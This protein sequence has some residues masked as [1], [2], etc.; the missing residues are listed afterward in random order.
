VAHGDGKNGHDDDDGGGDG[1]LCD[2]LQI[3]PQGV[4]HSAAVL[5]T[6]ESACLPPYD[7]RFSP[8]VSELGFRRTGVRNTQAQRRE[9]L[10]IEMVGL[11]L[12]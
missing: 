4:C 9:W 5:M 3:S 7:V 6:L 8:G 2:D 11:S 1:S 10:R 12:L